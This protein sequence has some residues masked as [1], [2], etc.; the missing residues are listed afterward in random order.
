MKKSE[1]IYLPTFNVAI[2]MKNHPYMQNISL[3]YLLILIF[4]IANQ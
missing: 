4:E 2:A 3:D 1:E